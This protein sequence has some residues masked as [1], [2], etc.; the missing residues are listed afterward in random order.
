MKNQINQN[1][2]VKTC[3]VLL[4]WC[5][6][7]SPWLLSHSLMVLLIEIGLN[8]ILHANTDTSLVQ[9]EQNEWNHGNEMMTNYHVIINSKN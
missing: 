6:F 1:A 4:Q 2:T 8:I 5:L 9:I 3:N 7:M